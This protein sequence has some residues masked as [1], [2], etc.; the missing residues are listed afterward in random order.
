MRLW[1]ILI[2][3][4]GVAAGTIATQVPVETAPQWSWQI[5]EGAESG[6][7]LQEQ[8]TE[9]RAIPDTIQN[10]DFFDNEQKEQRSVKRSLLPVLTLGLRLV[11]V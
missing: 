5:P 4:C 1:A 8:E 7:N 9:K 11:I 6:A 3:C 2:V 10:A